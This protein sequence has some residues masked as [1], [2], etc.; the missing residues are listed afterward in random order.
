MKA[1][2]KGTRIGDVVVRGEESMQSRE[3]R[4]H[5]EKAWLKMD[6]RVSKMGTTSDPHDSGRNGV[7]SGGGQNKTH[8]GKAR[9]SGVA[10]INQIRVKAV[11]KNIPGSVRGGL[12]GGEQRKEIVSTTEYK[13]RTGIGRHN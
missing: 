13:M 5:G 12:G 7:N 4:V 2:A 3:K 11:I 6:N 1:A 10:L 9:K 8:V